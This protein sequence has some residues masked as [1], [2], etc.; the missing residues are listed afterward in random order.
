ML[1]NQNNNCYSSRDIIIFYFGGP[2]N[3]W[4][5]PKLIIQVYLVVINVML[6]NQNNN[7]YSS[8]DIIIFYFGGPRNV[9]V[10]PKLIIQVNL[11]VINVMLQNQ[12]HNCYSSRDIQIFYFGGP[13]KSGEPQNLTSTSHGCFIHC[14]Q[15]LDLQHHPFSRY[16]SN[17]RNSI[18]KLRKAKFFFWLSTLTP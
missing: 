9:W 8:R 1:Q 13:R 11:V 6:Q 3:V 14:V 15:K 5:T 12:N 16:T 10:T 2:R 18:P 17:K 7:C 4:V